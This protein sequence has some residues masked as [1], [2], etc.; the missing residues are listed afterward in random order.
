MGQF[1]EMMLDG[2]ICQGCGEWLH[3]G[4]DGPGIPGFCFSCQPDAHLNAG[5]FDRKPFHCPDCKRRFR[6]E[7]GLKDHRRAA[8]GAAT[9]SAHQE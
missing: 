7:V 1:A 4:E 8:H 3:D 6:K 2:T 5:T 9:E